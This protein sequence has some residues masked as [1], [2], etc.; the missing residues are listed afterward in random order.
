MSS[1]SEPTGMRLS[2]NT[3]HADS[4]TRPASSLSAPSHDVSTWLERLGCKLFPRDRPLVQYVN[5]CHQVGLL[6]VL[7]DGPMSVR[8]VV[9][10]TRLNERG[11][12]ALLR[13]LCALRIAAKGPAGNYSLNE[14]ARE[15]FAPKSPFFI[16]N[17]L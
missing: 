15:Y 5:W 6:E 4:V 7:S 13:V 12:D 11:A 16:G 14:Q 1:S 17:E 2:L 9:S 10:R 8:E 3:A